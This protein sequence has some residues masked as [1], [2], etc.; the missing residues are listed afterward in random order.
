MLVRVYGPCRD[1]E[2]NGMFVEMLTHSATNRD[3]IC[4]GM[5]EH[6]VYLGAH[7]ADRGMVGFD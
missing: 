4:S 5:R 7:G 1:V 6:F 3:A 2:V